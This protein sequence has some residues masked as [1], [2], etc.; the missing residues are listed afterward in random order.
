M[1]VP[2][3]YVFNYA[4]PN[5]TRMKLGCFLLMMSFQV[6]VKKISFKNCGTWAVTTIC[7]CITVHYYT[8]KYHLWA[9]GWVSSVLLLP[10]ESRSSHCYT[11]KYSLETVMLLSM[12]SK[13]IFTFS[14]YKGFFAQERERER[15]THAYYIQ[16]RRE[17]II[18]LFY[19][20]CSINVLLCSDN[21]Y[22][23]WAIPMLG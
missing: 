10:F 20:I 22:G 1:K 19:R 4:F 12:H 7:E 15:H 23:T 6:P 13:A 5:E 17:W 14:F 8:I 16:V 3:G 21:F 11:E 18:F 2:K 9:N